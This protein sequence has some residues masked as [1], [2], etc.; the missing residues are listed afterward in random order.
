[1]AGGG[2]VLEGD[3]GRRALAELNLSEIWAIF[4]NGLS[5]ISS[6]KGGAMFFHPMGRTV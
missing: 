3:P 4:Q 6:E 1:M 5:G 2:S